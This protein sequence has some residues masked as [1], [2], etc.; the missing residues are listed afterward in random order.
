M[1][2]GSILFTPSL[3]IFVISLRKKITP[4][5]IIWKHFV[6]PPMKPP[7]ILLSLIIAALVVTGSL[8]AQT[9]TATQY[10]NTTYY[11]DGGTATHCGNTT[12]FS[13]ATTATQYGNTTILERD[14]ATATEYNLYRWKHSPAY[15]NTTLPMGYGDPVREY[16]LF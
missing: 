16:N 13:D 7:F 10:G 8:K 9:S 2:L 5:R 15:G 14:T 11:S 3:R 12:Y 4:Q 1:V 6:Y